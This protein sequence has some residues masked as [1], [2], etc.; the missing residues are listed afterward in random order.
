MALHAIFL[1]HVYPCYSHLTEAHTDASM[2]TYDVS[3][4]PFFTSK[5]TF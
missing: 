5:V 3:K 2:L 4:E 1:L